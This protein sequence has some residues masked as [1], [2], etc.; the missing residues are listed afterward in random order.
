MQAGR[1]ML[2]DVRGGTSSASDSLEF[3]MELEATEVRVQ[4][5]VLV[6]TRAMEG[7]PQRRKLGKR[8]SCP[9]YLER[10]SRAEIQLFPSATLFSF[11]FGFC[12]LSLVASYIFDHS[13]DPLVRRATTRPSIKLHPF[14][15]S[16]L[17]R[18]YYDRCLL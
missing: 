15:T 6:R 3:S 8:R 12:F 18:P 16:Y 11:C 9:F 1:K 4:C 5:L 14:F 2:Q 10:G 7:S 13:R 17:P